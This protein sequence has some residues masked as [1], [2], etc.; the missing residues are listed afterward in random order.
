MRAILLLLAVG[1]IGCGRAAP[2]EVASP[3]TPSRPSLSES[4]ARRIA[5]EAAEQVV[6]R[7]V[8]E[9]QLKAAYKSKQDP[10]T[11]AAEEQPAG[12]AAGAIDETAA[13][14]EARRHEA[15]LMLVASER[16]RVDAIRQDLN[17]RGLARVHP[18][19]V[20]WAWRG[21]G[22]DCLAEDLL[23]AARKPPP[24]SEADM[25][26]LLRLDGATLIEFYC[27]EP[28]DQLQRIQIA[29]Q[30]RALD[31]TI[32]DETII[33]SRR[34]PFLKPLIAEYMKAMQE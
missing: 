30:L 16:Q 7:T 33:E 3:T 28:L 24:D 13:E 26:Q 2:P 1:L 21:D 17:E 9:I 10:K 8:R 23:A 29:K 15:Y 32:P 14:A 27:L 18:E 4:D 19:D 22:R 11:T 5:Q 34:D 6:A 12:V 25:I 20:R 31:R